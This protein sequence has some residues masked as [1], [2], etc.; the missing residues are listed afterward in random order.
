MKKV[1]SLEDT[2]VY[3]VSVN[4][5]IYKIFDSLKKAQD[6]CVVD[7]F[8]HHYYASSKTKKLVS[9][10]DYN[11]KLL[12]KDDSKVIVRYTTKKGKPGIPHTTC[13]SFTISIYFVS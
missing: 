5:Q 11:Y 7:R 3:V 13:E 4:G 2:K 10:S 12:V 9:M 6:Y 8:K 1:K